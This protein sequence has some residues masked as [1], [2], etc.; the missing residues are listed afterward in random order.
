MSN[1]GTRNKFTHILQV[2]HFPI[3]TQRNLLFKA[4]FSVQQ[5][6]S[7]FHWKMDKSGLFSRSWKD[8][9]KAV[10][11]A[12]S[13]ACTGLYAHLFRHT[14]ESIG[15]QGMFST[16]HHHDSHAG[17]LAP[18]LPLPSSNITYSSPGRPHAI[19]QTDILK[20]NTSQAN[21]FYAHLTEG[22]DSNSAQDVFVHGLTN[23]TETGGW[24]G[25][26]RRYMQPAIRLQR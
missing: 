3:L 14:L 21:L 18:L 20:L 24:G 25:S 15:S 4:F 26:R 5:N 10:T 16:E 7:V 1:T 9:L 11:T 2:C 6:S 12:S 22:S 17:L 19:P 8:C 23:S 13:L